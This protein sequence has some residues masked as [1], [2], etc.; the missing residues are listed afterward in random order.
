MLQGIE[1]GREHQL[2]PSVDTH[3]RQSTEVDSRAARRLVLDSGHTLVRLSTEFMLHVTNFYVK[4]NLRSTKAVWTSSHGFLREGE[5]RILCWITRSYSVK[6]AILILGRD[7]RLQGCTSD[8]VCDCRQN[9][10]DSRASESTNVG[11]DEYLNDGSNNGA[12]TLESYVRQVAT[13]LSYA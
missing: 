6:L 1:A 8:F 2:G 5:P 10:G 12:S 13:T 4:V 7:A 9:E 3:M 11:T